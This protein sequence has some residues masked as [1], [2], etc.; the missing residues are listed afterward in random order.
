MAITAS[1]VERLKVLEQAFGIAGTLEEHVGIRYEDYINA[2]NYGSNTV[3]IRDGGLR[4]PKRLH[5]L[6]SFIE[7]QTNRDAFGFREENFSIT[8]NSPEA[9]AISD[10]N[11]II[12][13][14]SHLLGGFHVK[15]GSK[16]HEGR[17]SR[18]GVFA[19][20]GDMKR[21]VNTYFKPTKEEPADGY[22]FPVWV[23]CYL[24]EGG[25]TYSKT[26]SGDGNKYTEK[27]IGDNFNIGDNFS[28]SPPLS[29]FTKLENI[30]EFKVGSGYIGLTPSQ[31][32]Y[33]MLKDKGDFL[34]GSSNPTVSAYAN[35]RTHVSD[36]DEVIDGQ[37]IIGGN[38]TQPENAFYR[39]PNAYG[40]ESNFNVETYSESLK[41][42]WIG[43][44]EELIRLRIKFAETFVPTGAFKNEF[45]KILN[46]TLNNLRGLIRVVKKHNFILHSSFTEN[47]YLSAYEKKTEHLR[48]YVYVV[49]GVEIPNYEIYSKIYNTRIEVDQI[50]NNPNGDDLIH[51]LKDNLV[52]VMSRDLETPYPEVKPIA[53]PPT[54]EEYDALPSDSVTKIYFP[55]YRYA[56]LKD[57][58]VT[59]E[60]IITAFKEMIVDPLNNLR[61]RNKNHPARQPYH[62]F[63][64]NKLFVNYDGVL[65]TQDDL[66]YHRLESRRKI[67]SN[68]PMLFLGGPMISDVLD[69]IYLYHKDEYLAGKIPDNKAFV[70]YVYD[71]AR[72]L[73]LGRMEDDVSIKN[74][75]NALGKIAKSLSCISTL[76]IL[77]TDQDISSST[78]T[79]SVFNNPFHEFE[80]T[81]M[82][83]KLKHLQSPFVRDLPELTKTEELRPY[84]YFAI[85]D[86][87]Y[88]LEDV[89]M[90]YKD[91]WTNQV[92]G[93]RKV[94]ELFTKVATD[95]MNNALNVRRLVVQV[96]DAQ[97]G[98]ME[99]GT[100]HHVWG[101]RSELS[102]NSYQLWGSS[103]IA[104]NLDFNMVTRSITHV[105]LRVGYKWT[106][107]A[108]NGMH[109]RIS[110]VNR[111]T[112]AEDLKD[113]NNNVISF[114]NPLAYWNGQYG[115][116]VTR[117]S[118]LM[119]L[120][121]SIP[122]THMIR[123]YAYKQND[124][125][126][127]AINVD[128]THIKD[129]AFG[130]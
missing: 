13:H 35:K 25:V 112:F 116:Y 29:N 90:K 6:R 91:I 97:R 11:S 114:D 27:I 9:L 121:R 106:N 66:R 117:D 33:A 55:N 86:P 78:F 95:L 70:K 71:I 74:T 61:L 107:H 2:A 92:L 130:D 19:Y 53:L 126:G 42:K 16:K 51:R 77:Y 60:S 75:L 1:E 38:I 59:P 118:D 94:H 65:Y 36:L 68:D 10:I 39:F 96:R 125:S 110:A 73:T 12:A 44:I 102:P 52:G 101:R 69:D 67:V 58:V 105:R 8:D 34:N 56:K 84:Y 83:V 93:E 128:F 98:Y 48:Y 64:S 5:Y 113:E 49:H 3:N 15:G 28:Y 7:N 82:L 109:F 122:A 127:D 81:N 40:L 50:G 57:R 111:A 41:N 30:G 21:S 104:R 46:Y 123:L 100:W 17:Y 89:M 79:P 80:D 32:R 14:G 47:T 72:R 120:K 103:C 23:D 4:D 129:V 43:R 108:G 37:G 26:Y 124:T 62:E 20:T 45:I 31:I 18:H 119:R 76:E 24:R 88:A 54:Q 115:H 63:L 87:R 85:L 22:F 99:N